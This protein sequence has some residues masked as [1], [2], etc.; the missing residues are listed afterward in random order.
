MAFRRIS[1]QSVLGG[2]IVVL[3]ALLL[4]DTTGAF[5]TSAL[6]RFVPALFVA[7]GLYALVRS[8]FENL[9]G[10]A[11]VVAVAAAAQAVALG[12]VAV[13]DLVVFWPLLVVLF[14]VSVL[15]GR[16]RSR[17]AT[18][19]DAY[20]DSFALFGGVERRVTGET[21]AGATLTA[22]FGGAELDLRDA[23]P[24]DRPVRI[25]A[26]A[27]FGG[28]DVVVPRDWRVEM[29]VLPVFGAAED[30]RPRRAEEHDEVDLVLTGFAAFGGVSVVD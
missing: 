14:G 15:A 22:L 28:V 25:N 21:F 5:D 4:A 24:L 9:F 6:L 19:N 23:A 3:G 8:R 20:V 27:L 11:V 30:D 26:T 17:V 10:P 7:V 16:M 18:T 13:D 1:S 12:W 2:A 29:D